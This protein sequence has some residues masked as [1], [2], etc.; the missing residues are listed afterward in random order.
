MP[1]EDQRLRAPFERCGISEESSSL[2]RLT[3]TTSCCT[4]CEIK[5]L[6]LKAETRCWFLPRV[7]KLP[8]LAPSRDPP[9]TSR[10]AE[11]QRSLQSQRTPEALPSRL[12]LAT[13]RSSVSMR[14]D[15]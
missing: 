12:R 1:R 15:C 10:R 8:S 14:I 7:L 13:S 3:S 11:N 5:V 2:K 6:G 4:G 9:S